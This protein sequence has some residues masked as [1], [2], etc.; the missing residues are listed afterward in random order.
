MFDIEFLNKIKRHVAEREQK[1]YVK[2]LDELKERNTKLQGIIKEKDK[3]SQK[4][5]KKIKELEK[6]IERLELNMKTYAGMLFKMNYKNKEDT[7][8]KN[9]NPLKLPRG[10]VK[11]HKGNSRRTPTK[12]DTVVEVQ[13]L[14]KCPDC[15]GPLEKVN[16][17]S[18][19]HVVEDITLPIVNTVVT[20]YIKQRQFCKHCHKE[21]S[22]HDKEELPN[23]RFGVN[24]MSLIMYLRYEAKLPLSAIVSLLKL[25]GGIEITA[26][27]IE[28]QLEKSKDKLGNSYKDILTNIRGSP[29]KHADETGWKVGKERY[30][31]WIF[32]T[33]R[34]S[35]LGIAP[36]RGKEV[37][38][39]YLSA[40][41]PNDVLVRDG[42]AGYDCL[43]MKTQYCWAHII[44][45]A[46]DFA[47]LKGSCKEIKK[48]SK[49][50]NEIYSY[51]TN[52]EGQE[53]YDYLLKRLVKLSNTPTKCEAVRRVQTKL[54]KQ[55]EGLLTALIVKDVPLTNNQAERDLRPL[56]ISRKISFGSNSE[57]G[58]ETTSVNYSI[59]QTLK[60]QKL[61]SIPN[62][63]R[64]LTGENI[65]HLQD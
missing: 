31:A 6:R 1:R 19:E 44:R 57:T 29:V 13:E 8:V 2:H 43:N 10:G 32:C 5:K 30:C 48:M 7:N 47:K 52:N 9:P 49:E 58:A 46:R 34:E 53:A 37:A 23:A 12:I 63:T 26:S 35:F 33:P 62:I 22:S 64:L 25:Q 36:T 21:Y 38:I 61:L 45:Y 55:S 50:L 15:N 28:N 42:F 16:S 20:K 56:V 17:E 11:G 65:Y 41:S 54:K 3:Q 4:D 60:K 27:G 59:I 24:L 40:S 39:D 14:D 51:A 18:T